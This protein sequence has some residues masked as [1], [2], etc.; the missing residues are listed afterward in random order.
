MSILKNEKYRASQHCHQH[1][2]INLTDTRFTREQLN[3]LNLGFQYAM[4]E[5]PKNF[6][7]TLIIETENAIKRLDPY[8][9]NVYRHLACNKIKQ[10]KNANYHNALHKWHRHILQ[11]IK[12]M[13]INTQQSV[14]S[15][16][17]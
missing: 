10:I 15:K 1:R 6:I 14:N 3:T 7:N 11:Q 4:E 17:R 16:S 8:L 9:Q 2:V 13:L 12:Q 5:K